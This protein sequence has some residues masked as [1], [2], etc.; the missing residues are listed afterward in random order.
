M[1]KSAIHCKSYGVICKVSFRLE[2]E[3]AKKKDKKE[4]KQ[5]KEKEQ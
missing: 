2:D 1:I 3:K 4:K 5:K